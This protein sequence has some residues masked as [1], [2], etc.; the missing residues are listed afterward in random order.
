[1]HA[2]GKTGRAGIRVWNLVEICLI[3]L[4]GINGGSSILSGVVEEI[5]LRG[6]KDAQDSFLIGL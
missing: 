3:R 6:G 2:C 5:V 1:M 4:S